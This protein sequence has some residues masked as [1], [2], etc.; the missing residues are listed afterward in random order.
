MVLRPLESNRAETA[1]E[2]GKPIPAWA[3]VAAKQ[4]CRAAGYWLISQ[5]DHAHLSGELAAHFAAERFPRV[6]ATM[7]RAIGMHD[8]GWAIFPQE[9]NPLSPPRVGENGK[10]LAFVEFAPEDFLRAWSAS[11]ERAEGICPAG[12]IIVSRHFCELG[13]F[14][15]Q[16]GNHLSSGDCRLISGFLQHEDE[17][18]RRLQAICSATPAELDGLLEVLKFC[19]LLSLYLCS[20]AEAEAEFPQRLTDSPVR[21]KRSPGEDLYRLTPS[22]FQKNA[23]LRVVSLGVSASYFP[24]QGE[25]RVTT[26][27]FLLC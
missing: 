1:V 9:A 6:D 4:K 21:I 19:D 2:D 11:I 23:E 17:R 22:P 3:A 24:A 16:N 14:R 27:G 13:N 20:G 7:A 25:A 5:P 10:P 8:A 26:L 15:L 18:Q 12:G